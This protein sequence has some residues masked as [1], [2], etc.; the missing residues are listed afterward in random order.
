MDNITT[1][2]Q[3]GY[4]SCQLM[5]RQNNEDIKQDTNAV[6]WWTDKTMANITTRYQTGYQCCQLMDRQNNSQHNYKIPNRIPMLSIDGP[7]KQWRYQ[8]GYQSCQLMDRQNNEDT[9]Q[10]TKSC[11]LMDRQNNEDTKQ[12]TKSCQLMTDKTMKI[13]NRIPKLSIDES[14]KQ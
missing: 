1:R 12:D 7:T 11:Q 2:Y 5:D 9:K 14:T 10:D 6:N 4:Q 3:T 8:T 13:P